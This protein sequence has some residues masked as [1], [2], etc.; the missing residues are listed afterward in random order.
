MSGIER[1]LSTVTLADYA[2]NWL[3]DR[4]LRPR[5]VELYEGLLNLHILPHLG[6]YELGALNPPLEFGA[7][8]K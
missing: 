4:I 6:E 8:R 5:T 7:L 3:D 1:D 2:P